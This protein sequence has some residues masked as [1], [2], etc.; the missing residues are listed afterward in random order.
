MPT[1]CSTYG[2]AASARRSVE[3]LRGASVPGREVRLLLGEPTHDV[4]YEVVGGFAGP[5]PPDARVGTFAN[6]PRLRWQGHGTFAGDSDARRQGSFA[7]TDRDV[8]LTG[9]HAHVVGDLRV[10]RLLHDAGLDTA[11]T[12]QVVGELHTGHA[13]VLAESD[14]HEHAA[15]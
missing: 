1:L 2:D 3:A 5:V 14:A 15:A 6:V 11:T 12:D 13:V 8:V 9:A 10:R 7:D 4:R